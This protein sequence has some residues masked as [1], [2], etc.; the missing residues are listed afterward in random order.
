[1]ADPSSRRQRRVLTPS[2]AFDLRQALHVATLEALVLSRRWEP[3]ELAFQG[4]TS[5]HLVHGS[6]RFSE[7]LDFLVSNTLNLDA[8]SAS[9]QARLQDMPWLPQGTALQVGKA[10]DGHNPHAFMVSLGGPDVI[11]AVRVKVELWLTDPEPLS[12]VKIA[13]APVRLATGPAAGMQTFVPTA[14]L[15]EIYADKVFA[16]GA[17]PYLKPRD[18]FDLHWLVNRGAQ[19]ACSQ[20][21]LQVRL[22]TYPNETAEAWIDKALERNVE[23]IGAAP[24]IAK[25]LQRWLPSSWPMDDHKAGAMAETA[26]AAL[27]QGI[28]GMRELVAEQRN[29]HDMEP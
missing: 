20:E 11:G 14:D 21:Q 7:D 17:R 10:K 2:E 26:M 24:A 18:V 9:V 22:A 27:T 16:L 28:D 1:M 3:G 13:V 5:L 12:S 6:P 29:D 8:I 4:G 25:D 23:L 15:A 19:L